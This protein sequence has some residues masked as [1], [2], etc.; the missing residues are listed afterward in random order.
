MVKII[1]LKLSK[2]AD[3]KEFVSL[4]VQGSV[5]AIQSQQTGRFYLTAKTCSIPS[6]F[7]QSTAEALIGSTMPGKV[8]RV[9]SESYEYTI[10][11]SGQVITLSHRYEYQPEEEVLES[12]V[13]KSWKSSLDFAK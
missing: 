5:E 3:G 1:D 11:D 4:T 10:K 8:S 12:A 9:D 7:D 6:T 13:T 2:N